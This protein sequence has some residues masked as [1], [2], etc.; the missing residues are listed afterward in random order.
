M[1]RF[2]EGFFVLGNPRTSAAGCY[3]A[4]YQSYQAVSEAARRSRYLSSLPPLPVHCLELDGDFHSLPLIF[5]DQ[6]ADM[7]HRHRNSGEYNVVEMFF[8]LNKM[9]SSVPSM[10]DCSCGIAAILEKRSTDLWSPRNETLAQQGVGSVHGRVV[11]APST[12]P[13]RHSKSLDQLG[14][15]I[16]PPQ[17][18]TPAKTLP[19]STSTQLIPRHRNAFNNGTLPA[20][21][22]SSRNRHPS[23]TQHSG[24]FFPSRQQACSA[25]N[26]SLGITPVATLPRAKSTQILVPHAG[27]QQAGKKK[28]SQIKLSRF[29][30][31]FTLL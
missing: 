23:T 1:N 25:P 31:G 29:Y 19:R 3:D 22:P 11:L 20:T 15:E 14:P 26:P 17:I 21:V 7:Q 2:A 9:F 5:E 30:H 13:A 6:Y 28:L 8:L 10:D 16:I 27:H 18:P 4:N 12:L 24:L